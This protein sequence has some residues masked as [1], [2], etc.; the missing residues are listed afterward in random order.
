MGWTAEPAAD[1]LLKRKEENGIPERCFQQ[2]V[3]DVFRQDLDIL[4]SK[5]LRTQ[6]NL[7]AT[8]P[9]AAKNTRQERG[10]EYTLY[11]PA[12]VG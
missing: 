7:T 5:D 10:H 12:R 6:R 11:S 1:P 8:R 9:S 2:L 4:Q 3:T